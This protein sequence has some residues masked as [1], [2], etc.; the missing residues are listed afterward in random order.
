MT[1]SIRQN[2]TSD[3][4]VLKARDPEPIQPTALPENRTNRVPSLNAARSP[5]AVLALHPLH[6]LN[7]L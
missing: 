6:P 3:C 1:H 7:A 5:A 2:L 4:G